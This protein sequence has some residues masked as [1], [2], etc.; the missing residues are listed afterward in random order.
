[1]NDFHTVCVALSRISGYLSNQKL[2]EL[3]KE[4]IDLPIQTKMEYSLFNQDSQ[5]L[6]KDIQVCRK[7]SDSDKPYRPLTERLSSQS[8]SSLD[9]SHQFKDKLLHHEEEPEDDSLFFS[10]TEKKEEAQ[11]K[12]SKDFGQAKS[13][14]LKINRGSNS[15]RPRALGA[16]SKSTLFHIPDHRLLKKPFKKELSSSKPAISLKVVKTPLQ[17]PK[18]TIE[19]ENYLNIQ[20]V[21]MR[22]AINHKF[23]LP[24]KPKEL[25]LG[26]FDLPKKMST[27]R[28]K[29]SFDRSLSCEDSRSERSRASIDE[30]SQIS[31]SED[32]SVEEFK[33]ESQNITL[34]QNEPTRDIKY[35]EI[36]KVR[37]SAFSNPYPSTLSR[38]P[39]LKVICGSPE[40]SILTDHLCLNKSE[41]HPPKKNSVDPTKG[42]NPFSIHI[43]Q[44][45]GFVDKKE[46]A[47]KISQM[48]AVNKLSLSNMSTG[49]TIGRPVGIPLLSTTLKPQISQPTRRDLLSSSSKQVSKKTETSR[50]F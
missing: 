19:N 34:L 9:E 20:P 21:K 23:D 49:G 10:N 45:K 30:V 26:K 17:D 43:L 4:L 41:V 25:R 13:S 48:G 32:I 35:S 16:C 12:A 14:T 36:P 46:S 40:N 38:L 24:L 2:L 31:S 11:K 5:E 42:I 6:K 7:S 29:I 27:C 44:K 18:K 28:S 50:E 15:L 3:P 37:E 22:P 1:M 8:S 39:K 47:V 33:I